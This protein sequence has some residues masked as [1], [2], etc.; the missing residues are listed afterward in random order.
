MTVGQY[1]WRRLLPA[2]Q[3]ADGDDDGED[4]DA[5]HGEQRP[6]L[7]D[8]HRVLQRVT[9]ADV[10]VDGDGA[11]RHDGRRAAQDVH[12]R[13]DVAEDPTEHPVIQN[14]QRHAGPESTVSLLQDSGF[15]SELHE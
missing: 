4:P 6:L 7:C 8:D 2:Q 9:N 13:P 12:R 3:R 11:Q 15:C 14:L 10:A 5:Q 1:L